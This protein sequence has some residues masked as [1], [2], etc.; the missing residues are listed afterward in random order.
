MQRKE[1]TICII[2]LLLHKIQKKYIISIIKEPM[3]Q[4]NI[5]PPKRYEKY[6]ENILFSEF[7]CLRTICIHETC[8]FHNLFTK[9]VVWGWGYPNP[10]TKG[11]SAGVA[12]LYIILE[13]MKNIF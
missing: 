4:Y 10:D 7:G 8:P 12:E 1:E 6:E 5:K 3:Y 2:C 13:D 11:A 9:N